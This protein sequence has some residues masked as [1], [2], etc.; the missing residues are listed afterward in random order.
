MLE[1]A[2]AGT[3]IVTGAHTENFEAIVRMLDENEAIITLPP[4]QEPSITVALCDV[5]ESLLDSSDKRSTLGNNALRMVEEN[6]GAAART[7]ALIAPLFEKC[8]NRAEPKSLLATEA[9]N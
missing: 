5:F 7:L 9:G 6:R 2:A 8:S 3:A 1:P 4:L